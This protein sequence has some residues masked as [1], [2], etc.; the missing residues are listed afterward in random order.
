MS[1]SELRD[2]L[3]ALEKVTPEFEAKYHDQMK[4]V[5][6]RPLTPTTRIAN[7]VAMLMG[8]GF[9]I[10]FSTVAVAVMWLEPGFPLVGRLMFAA[11]ALFGLAFAVLSGLILKRGSISLTFWRNATLRQLRTVHPAAFGLTWVFCVLVMVFCQMMGS[12]APDAAKGNQIILGGIVGMVLFGIP[13]TI[14]SCATEAEL[15]LR[16]KFLQL[17]L[18]LT[19]LKDLVKPE[20]GKEAHSKT[21]DA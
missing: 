4:A 8:I 17:E 7:V 1:D 10:L 3:L 19:E 5:F 2:K 15:L 21:E 12:Q 18:Q 9:F 20:Q 14:L 13:I 11:G 6:E 16:E